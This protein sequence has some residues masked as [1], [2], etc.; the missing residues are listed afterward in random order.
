MKILTNIKTPRAFSKVREYAWIFTMLVAFGGL[1]VPKLGLLVFGVIFTLTVVSLTRGRFWCGNYCA[2]GSLFDRL[3]MPFSRNVKIPGIL[4]SKYTQA[5]VFSLFMYN[6]T[7]KFIRVSYLWGT[8]PFWDR[9]GFVFVGSYLMVTIVGGLLGLIIAPRT[10]CQVCPMGMMQKLTYGLGKVLRLT[11][12]SDKKVTISRSDKCV[13]CAKC[14]RVCP[15]Q[16]SPY[17]AFSTTRQFDNENCIRCSVCVESCPLRLLTLSTES[18]AEDLIAIGQQ[19]KRRM[20]SAS[21]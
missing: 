12:M 14:A 2:H 21:D 17:T 5:A 3:L 8:L 18:Q 16:L 19:S 1:W 13:N 9:L 4:R 10:W 15:M 20:L 6:L 7:T 11:A